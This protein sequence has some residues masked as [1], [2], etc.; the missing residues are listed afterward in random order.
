M[1]SG[2]QL[3]MHQRITEPSSSGSNSYSRLDAWEYY[4]GIDD[5]GGEKRIGME[6]QSGW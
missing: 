2:K 1:F 5:K 3:M 4:T 6:S